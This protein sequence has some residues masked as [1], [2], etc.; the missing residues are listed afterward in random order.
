MNWKDAPLTSE[1]RQRFIDLLIVG[2]LP[3]S[4]P[5]YAVLDCPMELALRM[6]QD[7]TLPWTIFDDDLVWSDP[8]ANRTEN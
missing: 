6:T 3:R 4:L 2:V 7:E 1:A 5:Q 8:D